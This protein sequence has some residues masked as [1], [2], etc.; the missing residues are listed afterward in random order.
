MRPDQETG[1]RFYGTFC[2]LL[3]QHLPAWG[4]TDTEKYQQDGKQD[5]QRDGDN[6]QGSHP[7]LET[8]RN[9]DFS[10][11]SPPPAQSRCALLDSQILQ[12][13]NSS[14]SQV[15]NRWPLAKRRQ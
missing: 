13:L 2:S 5:P 7:T 8:W 1:G 3:P 9:G 6:H 4:L 15:S 12:C 10:N 11:G 14:I